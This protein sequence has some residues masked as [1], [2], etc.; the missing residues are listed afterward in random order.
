MRTAAI[1]AVLWVLGGVAGPVVRAADDGREADH[2]ALRALRAAVVTAINSRDVDALMGCLAP[3][4]VFTAADQTALTDRA[5]VDAFL[6]R[7]FKD[8]KGPLK[9]LTSQPTADILTRFTDA[10]SGYCYGSVKDTY[11]LKDGRTVTVHGRWTAV[12]VKQGGA[13]KVAAA[14]AGVNFVDNPVMTLRT[15]S[16]YRKLGVALGLAALP[17]QE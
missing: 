11:T 3:E 12:V 13:W 8:E 14:H 6:S 2:A 5:A 16:W 15:M 9:S 4:F 10:N 7:W 17:G 1:V